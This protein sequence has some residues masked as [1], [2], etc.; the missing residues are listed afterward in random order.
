MFFIIVSFTDLFREIEQNEVNIRGFL[1]HTQANAVNNVREK[2]DK[3][4]GLINR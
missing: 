2:L 3:S 1:G 4:L